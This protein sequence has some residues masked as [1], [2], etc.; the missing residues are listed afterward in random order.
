MAVQVLL[1]MIRRKRLRATA[2]R[3]HLLLGRRLLDCLSVPVALF[4]TVGA[5]PLF[6]VACLGDT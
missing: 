2:S 4:G 1:L 6:L 3:M 5:A